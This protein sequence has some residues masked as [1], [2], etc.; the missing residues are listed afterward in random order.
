LSNKVELNDLW[1][2]I[3]EVISSGGEFQLTPYGISM[4]PLIRPGQDSVILV[5]P[6]DLKK[7]DIVLYKRCDGSFVLHRIMLIQKD[8]YIMCGDNQ[9]YPERDIKKEQILALVKDIYR[10]GEKI[11]TETDEYKK[12]IKS[13]YKKVRKS[14]LRLFLSRIKHKI[15][16]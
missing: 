9:N 14:R 7:T 11:N 6:R 15:F 13:L 10:D 5:S 16:K 2:V 4:L 1:P 3:D 8:N 12:Y